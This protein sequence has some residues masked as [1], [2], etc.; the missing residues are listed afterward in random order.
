MFEMILKDTH[1]PYRSQN[2]TTMS[3]YK[4]RENLPKKEIC[5]EFNALYV[6]IHFNS[7]TNTQIL[8]F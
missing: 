1:V 4:E 8:V 7:M 3:R 6:K 5:N 2:A